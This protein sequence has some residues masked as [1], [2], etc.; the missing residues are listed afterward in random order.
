[1]WFLREEKLQGRKICSCHLIHPYYIT[2]W[3]K[4]NILLFTFITSNSFS[5]HFDFLPL[6][7]LASMLTEPLQT[8][9]SLAFC[10]ASTQPL[11]RISVREFSLQHRHDVLSINFCFYLSLYT[12]TK[13]L[14]NFYTLENSH[15]F[16]CRRK[17]NI[18]SVLVGRRVFLF[19]FIL[20][21][22]VFKA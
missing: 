7:E 13:T 21:S 8:K 15:I 6:T 9:A 4:F 20:F 3:A 11:L 22:L 1:M 16:A 18:F 17:R 10:A 2:T 14:K 12:H 19:Y 5:L